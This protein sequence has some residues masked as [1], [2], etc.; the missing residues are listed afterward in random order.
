MV[1][2]YNCQKYRITQMLTDTYT[3]G[4]AEV[5]VLIRGVWFSETFSDMPF[6]YEKEERKIRRVMRRKADVY[7]TR[8]SN[9]QED[10]Y[11]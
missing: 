2:K 10:V 11:D 6:I 1:K 5:K 4:T 7:F 9:K 3:D 8:L